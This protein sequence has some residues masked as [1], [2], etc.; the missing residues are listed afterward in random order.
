MTKNSM[1]FERPNTGFPTKKDW[2]EFQ[3]YE[4]RIHKKL[5]KIRGK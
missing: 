3:K 5:E 4:D 2:E 1:L